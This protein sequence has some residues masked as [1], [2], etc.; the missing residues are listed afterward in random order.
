MHWRC[1]S[2]R[3]CSDTSGFLI[4]V[5]RALS[6]RQRKPADRDVGSGVS[7]ASWQRSQATFFSKGRS[8]DNILSNVLRSV[9]AQDAL[10]NEEPGYQ[11]H[12][13]LRSVKWAIEPNVLAELIW[14]VWL[15]PARCRSFQKDRSLLVGDWSETSGAM[16]IANA[17]SG[18]TMIFI[19]SKRRKQT[20]LPN[21]GYLHTVE[22]SNK[23]TGLEASVNSIVQLFSKFSNNCSSSVNSIVQW[24]QFFRLRR[25]KRI[26]EKYSTRLVNWIRW[27]IRD[28]H[29]NIHFLWWI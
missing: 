17:R 9:L 4:D 10:L 20:L 15:S 19:M 29:A 6:V 13:Q 14:A 7:L 24:L 11:F 3:G 2:F 18:R 16:L 1:V 21:Q 26:E 23:F 22:I 27:R 28:S 12:S 25:S 8:V 5:E